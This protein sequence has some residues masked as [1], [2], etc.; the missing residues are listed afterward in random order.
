MG[1]AT[2][3]TTTWGNDIR[4]DLGIHRFNKECLQTTTDIVATYPYNPRA[5]GFINSYSQKLSSPYNELVLSK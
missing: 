1:H 2:F 4:Y 3:D 5:L